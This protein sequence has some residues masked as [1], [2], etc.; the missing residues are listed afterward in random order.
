MYSLLMYLL[1]ES[2]SPPEANRE[3][4]NTT[5]PLIVEYSYH[6][7]DRFQDLS[8]GNQGQRSNIYFLWHHGV[9]VQSSFALVALGMN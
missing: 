9:I 2:R 1:S 7:E 6:C 4:P 8:V 3:V 5:L